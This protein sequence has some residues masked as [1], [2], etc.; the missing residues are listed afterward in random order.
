[1]SPT[2]G[3]EGSSE[4]NTRPR[5]RS[6]TR[7]NVFTE[8]GQMDQGRRSDAAETTHSGGGGGVVEGV[9]EGIRQSVTGIL[10]GA[11][12]AEGRGTVSVTPDRREELYAHDS[13][14]FAEDGRET[15]FQLMYDQMSKALRE[16]Q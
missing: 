13:R 7:V 15:Q 12:N 9:I 8:L 10:G 3:N 2:L 5:A 6:Q 14:R 16:T 11:T 4:P 1:M